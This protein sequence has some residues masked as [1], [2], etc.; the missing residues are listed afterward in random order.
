MRL[1]MIAIERTGYQRNSA[2]LNNL[3]N[4]VKY[5]IT[6]K[7]RDYNLLTPVPVDISYD[8]TLIAKYPEDI[9]KMVSNFYVFF[10]NDIYVMCE[11]PKY[12]GVKMK[13]QIVMA[14]SVSEDW[15]SELDATA[16]DFTTATIQFTFKTYLFGGTKKAKKNKT[17]S[18]YLSTITET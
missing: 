6:S 14:D 4:E 1:P 16:D 15:Q 5:E 3:H 8:V 18:T 17:L 2:R 13:N 10:N 9:D 7:N 12:E 11:H